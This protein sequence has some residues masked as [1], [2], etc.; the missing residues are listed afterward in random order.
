MSLSDVVKF[1]RYRKNGQAIMAKADQEVRGLAKQDDS[2]PK[3]LTPK[4]K[5]DQLISGGIAPSYSAIARSFPT[6]AGLKSAERKWSALVRYGSGGSATPGSRP[7]LAGKG[8]P[9]WLPVALAMAGAWLLKREAA[10]AAPAPVVN[11]EEEEEEEIDGEGEDDQE[12]EGE[13]A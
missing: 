12:P 9:D 8:L 2:G 13:P 4:D 11:P 6:W 5:M 7:L 3:V 1:N 10:K